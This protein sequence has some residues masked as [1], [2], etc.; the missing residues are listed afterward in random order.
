MAATKS[1]I[2][3]LAVAGTLAA[4]LGVYAGGWNAAWGQSEPVH[5]WTY[6][7]TAPT[8]G[9]PVA[10]YVVEYS[11]NG[12]VTRVDRVAGTSFTIPVE[13][14]NDYDLKVAAV[15]ALGRMGPFST[16][17][18]AETF[19]NDPPTNESGAGSGQ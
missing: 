15:D 3:C 12:V 8:T 16:P 17:A 6:T 11:V 9:S 18:G 1:R 4:L 2:F 7:W 10:Y 19:E 5:N 14:G 13:L